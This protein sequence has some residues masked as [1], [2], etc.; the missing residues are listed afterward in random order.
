MDK[1]SQGKTEDK[2]QNRQASNQA[3]SPNQQKGERYKSNSPKQSRQQVHRIQATGEKVVTVQKTK[4]ERTG[5]NSLN[6]EAQEM[7]WQRV[8]ENV[9]F[10]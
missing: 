9:Q 6:Q 8:E 10:K 1:N 2:V 7:N 3:V 5:K 4:V